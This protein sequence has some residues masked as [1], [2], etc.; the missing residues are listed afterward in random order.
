[1][2]RHATVDLHGIVLCVY[3]RKTWQVISTKTTVTVFGLR[4][5]KTRCNCLEDC[6]SS[7]YLAGMQH[8]LI[9]TVQLYKHHVRKFL[10]SSSVFLTQTKLMQFLLNLVQD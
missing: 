5:V 8:I 4:C 9:G 7:A 10:R 6:L 2:H 1:M 3:A